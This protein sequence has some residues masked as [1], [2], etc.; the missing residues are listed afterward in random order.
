MTPFRWKFPPYLPFCA[1]GNKHPPETWELFNNDQNI[2]PCRTVTGSFQITSQLSLPQGNVVTGQTA[3]KSTWFPD[4][5]RPKAKLLKL[6]AGRERCTE[7]QS[8][9]GLH[10]CLVTALSYTLPASS[11]SLWDDRRPGNQQ[12]LRTSLT[13]SSP[14]YK[15]PLLCV[16]QRSWI[17]TRSSPLYFIYD[18]VENS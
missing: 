4:V 9:K 18:H 10:H 16:E 7:N 11:K 6:G 1:L 13:I 15:M 14:A 5:V 17:N 12:F 8:T 2:F 3:T